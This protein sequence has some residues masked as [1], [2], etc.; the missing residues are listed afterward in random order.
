MKVCSFVEPK[1]QT[2]VAV[3]MDN[4]RSSGGT[5][6]KSLTLIIHRIVFS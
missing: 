3:G 2:S 4:A 1:R 6:S 5:E